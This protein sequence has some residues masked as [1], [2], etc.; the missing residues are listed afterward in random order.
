LG[1]FRVGEDCDDDVRS[2]FSHIEELGRDV[3]G[4]EWEEEGVLDGGGFF[5]DLFEEVEEEALFDS[6]ALGGLK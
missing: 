2:L 6:F 4:P 3:F 5:G 1:D